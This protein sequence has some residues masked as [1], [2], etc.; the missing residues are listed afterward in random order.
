MHIL[1]GADFFFQCW[2]AEQWVSFP[3]SYIKSTWIVTR[4]GSLFIGQLSNA[5]S[6]SFGS[7]DSFKSSLSA[8]AVGVQGSGWAWLGYNPKSKSLAI[9]SCANQ[10]PLQATTGIFKH[11][12]P[13]RLAELLKL[14]DSC[15]SHFLKEAQ[16]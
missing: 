16:L 13:C 12:R 14:C 5:I 3:Y 1:G 9:A 6:D 2:K 11:C 10:D 7:F 4:H 8:A 15:T